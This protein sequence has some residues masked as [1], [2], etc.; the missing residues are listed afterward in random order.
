MNDVDVVVVGVFGETASLQQRLPMIFLQPIGRVSDL[1][2]DR[3][4]SVTM[5][6]NRAGLGLAECGHW[7]KCAA[8]GGA[9]HPVGRG[10]RAA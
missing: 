5:A 9:V 8:L 7:V 10:T 1:L 3:D 6:E 2:V 4:H